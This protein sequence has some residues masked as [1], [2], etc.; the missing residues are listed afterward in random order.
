MELDDILQRIIS[1]EL[2][3]DI[4]EAEAGGLW[5][6]AGDIVF[7]SNSDDDEELQANIYYALW[8]IAEKL[9]F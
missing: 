9:T 2:T 8:D 6:Y 3:R 7:S 4:D 5:D 1:G